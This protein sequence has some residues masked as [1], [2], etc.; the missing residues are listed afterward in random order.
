MSKEE[1][2]SAEK[3]K[4][5]W[6]SH[7]GQWAD[8]EK[9]AAAGRLGAAKTNA[10][11]RRKREL[12]ARMKDKVGMLNEAVSAVMAENEDLLQQ[13]FENIA[14]KAADPNDDKALV[15]AEMLLKHLSL[16]HI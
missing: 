14:K 6:N 16:I 13:V 8:K 11:Q 12:E 1:D 5:A 15:A 4:Q 7:K 10:I 9:A 2:K 3:P